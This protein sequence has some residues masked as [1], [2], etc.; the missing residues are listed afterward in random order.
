MARPKAAFR[1][2]ACG[3][4][5]GKWVGRCPRCGEFATVEEGPTAAA[6]TVGLRTTTPATV[7]TPARPVAA[8]DAT[9]THHQPTGIAEFDRV[10][11]G[12][13]VAGGVVL[14]AAEPGFGKSTLLLDVANRATRDGRPALYVTGEE[15]AAQVKLRADRIGATSDLLY[16]AAETDVAVVAAHIEAIAPAFVVV[17]S[18]QALAS[19]DVDGRT[20]GVAQTIEVASYLTR[21][22]KTRSIPMVLVGQ[23]TKANELAGPRQVEHLCDVVIWGEGDKH[24]ALRMLRATKNRY[25]AADEV[26][27]FEHTATGLAEVADP[28]RLFL[29]ART[30]PVP[31]TCITMVLEGRRVIAA[32]VQAL[33]ARSKLPVPRRGSSGLDAAR[34]AM[35]QAAAERHARLSLHDHDVYCA[36]VGGVRIV[37][38]AADLAVVLA[39]ASAAADLPVRADIVAI[40]EVALTGNLRAVPELGRRLAEAA[41]QGF[42]VALI[43]ATTGA[44]VVA[45]PSLRVVQIDSV[46]R[47]V[48]ALRAMNVPAGAGAGAVASGR[49]TPPRD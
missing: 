11:G 19:A 47:A 36:T 48:G 27:C 6:T 12:G 28:S 4:T 18:I 45:P 46:S 41:R 34:L 10:L 14:L 43:P 29:D 44:A 30:D 13:L 21:V 15:S 33:V 17:D 23:A 16:I 2:S 37:E 42:R 24:S 31:G 1:C 8:I 9:A 22:A 3:A 5:F 7:T 49:D 25:G 40:G 26:G 38:P 39:L 35:T 20:G 32:E